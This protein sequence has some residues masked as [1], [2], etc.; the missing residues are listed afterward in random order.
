MLGHALHSLMVEHACQ[1]LLPKT[2]EGLLLSTLSILFP[3]PSERLCI[4]PLVPSER[5]TSRRL[6][7]GRTTHVLFLFGRRGIYPLSS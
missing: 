6:T 7:R 3:A 5:L 2:Q 1:F 4:P